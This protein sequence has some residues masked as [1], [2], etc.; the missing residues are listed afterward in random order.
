[1]TPPH[2]INKALS[3]IEVLNNYLVN[4]AVLLAAFYDFLLKIVFQSIA[5]MNQALSIIVIMLVIMVL[6]LSV[7]FYALGI[8]LVILIY[9]SMLIFKILKA[10]P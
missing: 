10:K 7:S 6:M 1:M 4:P 9:L 5:L 8:I 2:N 3:F